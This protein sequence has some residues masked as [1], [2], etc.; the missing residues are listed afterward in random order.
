MKE[1][2][3]CLS[4]NN[5]SSC[6]DKMTWKQFLM[7]FVGAVVSV[8]MLVIL[9]TSTNAKAAGTVPVCLT[10]GQVANA[11]TESNRCLTIFGGGVYDFTLARKWDL[12]GHVGKHLCG[13][14]YTKETIEEGPHKLAVIDKFYYTKVCG[15]ADSSVPTGKPILPSVLLGMSWFR[16]SAYASLIFFVLNFAT[17]FAM[18]WG[19]L[20]QPWKGSKPGKDKNDLIGAFPWTHWH[21]VWAW[22][23]IFT[24]SVHGLLGFAGVLFG[25]WY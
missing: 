17:C 16:F 25:K 1:C 20:S 8:V 18:P 4:K 21:K 14:E 22:L 19:K 3:E 13:K 5:C 2:K 12:T 15:A 10:F 24:L 6:D 23:A 7:C 11:V 9:S